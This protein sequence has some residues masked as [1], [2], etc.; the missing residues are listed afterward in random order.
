MTTVAVFSADE[1]TVVLRARLRDAGFAAVGLY[2]AD[3]HSGRV[4]LREF[5][6]RHRPDVVLYDLPG[7][8]D[9]ELR[10]AI[11]AMNAC[12]ASGIPCVLTAS[13]VDSIPELDGDLVAC[14]LLRP[15]NVEFAQ[16]AIRFALGDADERERDDDGG[17]HDVDA[18]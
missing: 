17:E 4:D 5:L 10:G 18:A 15:C 8:P 2:I 11:A 1:D 13:D 3:L 12:R 16:L 14:V 9:A 7:Q 6:R